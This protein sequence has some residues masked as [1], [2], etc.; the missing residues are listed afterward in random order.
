MKKVYGCF[1]FFLLAGMLTAQSA[2][3]IDELLTSNKITYAQAVYLVFIGN[4]EY[5][6]TAKPGDIFSE[7]VKRKWVSSTAQPDKPITVAHYA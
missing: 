3:F 1:M 4:G 5:Q 7:A 6:D 2:V